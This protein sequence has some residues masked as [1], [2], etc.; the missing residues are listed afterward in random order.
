MHCWGKKGLIAIWDGNERAILA[1]H[2]SRVKLQTL[3]LFPG[4]GYNDD[5]DVGIEVDDSDAEKSVDFNSATTTNVDSETG[6][7]TSQKADEEAEVEEQ[8]VAAV[9]AHEQSSVVPAV[10][11]SG[12]ICHAVLM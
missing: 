10:E 3:H 2:A 12:E 1:Q 11:A 6:V 9:V 8:L 4:R 5:S 7:V